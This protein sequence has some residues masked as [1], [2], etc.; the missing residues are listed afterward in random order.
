MLDVFVCG[1][2]TVHI[3]IKKGHISVTFLFENGSEI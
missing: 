1:E 3:Y 2:K